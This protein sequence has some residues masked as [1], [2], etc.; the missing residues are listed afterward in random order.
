MTEDEIIH[1]MSGL[2]LPVDVKL[3]TELNV[4][5]AVV[6]AALQYGC[7]T[8]RANLCHTRRLDWFQMCYIW[9]ICKMKC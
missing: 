7:E 6:L 2:M 4:C 1:Y 8:G 3:S 9:C 5:C